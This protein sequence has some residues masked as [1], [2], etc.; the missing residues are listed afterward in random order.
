[1]PGTKN[2]LGR[3]ITLT[4]DAVGEPGSR[5]FRLLVEAEHGGACLWLEKEQLFQLAIA[6][7]RL[8][9]T[10]DMA[11]GGGPASVPSRS[12]D[13]YHEFQ[14]GRLMISEDVRGPILNLLAKDQED[15]DTAEATVGTL[16]DIDQLKLLSERALEVC[17]AGRPRCPLCGTPMGPEGHQCVRTNGYHREMVDDIPR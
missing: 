13:A 9:S 14:V 12:G 6:I 2:D 5:R 11:S 3:A 7:Q 4:A 1:M 8:L 10:M 15:A 17:A 16:V